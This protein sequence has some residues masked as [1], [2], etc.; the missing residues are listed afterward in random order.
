MSRPRV[1]AIGMA[2]WDRLIVTDFYPEAGSYAIVRRTLEQSGGTTANT[3]HALA[4]LGI[5]VSFAAKVGDDDE[6]RELRRVLEAEGCD[7]AHLTTRDGELSDSAIIVVSG[8]GHGVDRT[9][10]WHQGARL[11]HGDSLPLAELFAH[12][13]VI[14]DVDDSRLRRFIVDLPTHTSPWTRFLGSLTYLVEMSP[15]EGLEIALRHDYLAGNQRELLYVTGCDDIH[16]AIR[17]VQQQM[18]YADLRMFAIS[19]GPAG[20]I[21]ADHQSTTAVPAF[22]VDVVDT[23]GAGDAF[24]AGVALGILERREPREIG[25]LANAMG[26]MSIRELGARSSLPTRSELDHFLSHATL[27]TDS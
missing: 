9:I 22:D 2:S 25:R 14:L 7:C 12:D 8:A 23:T 21:L 20:C 15:R 18:I 13:L 1:A 24:A 16:A 5:P 17:E 3:V 6:G 26:A 19:M 27:R 11:K 4:R 10:Y